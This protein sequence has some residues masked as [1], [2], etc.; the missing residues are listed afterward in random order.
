MSYRGARPSDDGFVQWASEISWLRE[1]LFFRP[2]LQI[3]DM[4]PLMK[5][6]GHFPCMPN[7]TL[8]DQ[9]T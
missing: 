5:P 2:D 9:K 1:F 8:D 3:E 4:I 6:I 7:H